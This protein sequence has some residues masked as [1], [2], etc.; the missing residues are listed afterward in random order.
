MNKI[1]QQALFII[2]IAALIV[3][4]LVIDHEKI[5]SKFFSS[6]K[7]ITQSQSNHHN[8]VDFNLPHVVDN[9]QYAMSEP[10]SEHSFFIHPCNMG[11]PMDPAAWMSMMMR[12]MNYM[13]MTQMMQQ[14]TKMPTGMTNPSATWMSPHMMMPN[15]PNTAKQPLSPKEYEKWYNEQLK[16]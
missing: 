12:M 6:E 5:E 10:F 13:Q 1:V 11:N 14:M 9:E 3:A 2:P 15:Q 8:D 7:S 4:P 16:K